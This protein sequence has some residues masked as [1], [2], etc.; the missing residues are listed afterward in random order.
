MYGQDARETT[1]QSRVPVALRAP[2]VPAPRSAPPAVGYA[3]PPPGTAQGMHMKA[4]LEA[5]M[6]QA[7]VAAQSLSVSVD[8]RARELAQPAIDDYFAD[9]IGEDELNRRKA[10]ANEAANAELGNALDPVESA[11]G[12]YTAASA[13]REAAE[14]ALAVA[15]RAEEEAASVVDAE[16]RALRL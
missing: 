12:A 7:R 15:V 4:G 9:R 16:L 11:Y 6:G 10:D 3:A 14:Q 5:R 13:A 1:L 8:Q 2:S